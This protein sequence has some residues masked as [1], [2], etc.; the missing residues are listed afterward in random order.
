MRQFLLWPSLED[1]RKSNGNPCW[2]VLTKKT[3][4]VLSLGLANT[5]VKHELVAASC[6]VEVPQA[7]E[8]EWVWSGSNTAFLLH[9]NIPIQYNFICHE[10]VF[11]TWCFSSWK[12]KSC[13]THVFYKNRAGLWFANLCSKPFWLGRSVATGGTQTNSPSWRW[14]K[15]KCRALRKPF[16]FIGCSTCLGE[17]HRWGGLDWVRMEKIR[18][19]REV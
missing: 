4:A 8:N 3:V 13:L 2:K 5:S 18:D 10:I 19:P 15:A 14:L 12:F 7:I 6:L 17:R 9:T 1:S 16:E 11:F